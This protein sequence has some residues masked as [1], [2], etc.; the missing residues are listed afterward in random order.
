MSTVQLSNIISDKLDVPDDDKVS[1]IEALTDVLQRCRLAPN[2]DSERHVSEP[3]YDL[4]SLSRIRR[5]HQPEHV[6]A[7]IRHAQTAP[8]IDS[9]VSVRRQLLNAI[10]DVM[11]D[12]HDRSR[13]AQSRL[14]AKSGS[15]RNERWCANADISKTGNAANARS[16]A[17]TRSN[18]V[19]AISI[20]FWKLT[21]A[22][23]V[24]P[25]VEHTVH[26]LWGYKS[27]SDVARSAA[28]PL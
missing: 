10:H 24:L 23:V 8:V 15:E 26:C 21:L 18:E 4:T 25:D 12:E 7:G 11:R 19:C 16:A 6:S 14:G 27:L 1:G 2:E 22:S 28:S 17:E 5:D 13:E 3:L 20:N 9:N